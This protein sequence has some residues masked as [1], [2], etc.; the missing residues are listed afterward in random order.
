M[1]HP[2]D[3]LLI[4]NGIGLRYIIGK[5]RT[6]FRRDIQVDGRFI[7]TSVNTHATSTIDCTIERVVSEVVEIISQEMVGIDIEVVGE[8]GEV[9]VVYAT[10]HQSSLVVFVIDVA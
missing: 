7:G 3:K 1:C 6:L 9:L 5:R 8:V 4:A 10:R 2:T